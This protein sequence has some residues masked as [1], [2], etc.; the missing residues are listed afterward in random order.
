MPDQT[1]VAETPTPRQRTMIRLNPEF[2]DLVAQVGF[3]IAEFAET[4]DVAKATIYALLNP[5]QHPERRGG[6]QRKTAWKLAHTY[7]ARA[8]MAPKDAYAVLIFEETR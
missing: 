4:A 3:S 8:G 5:G 2:P 6:M 1:V 7:A